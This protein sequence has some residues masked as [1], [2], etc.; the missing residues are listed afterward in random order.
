MT[1]T[2][3]PGGFPYRPHPHR[4]SG[5]NPDRQNIGDPGHCED[6]CSVGHLIA[7]PRYGCGDVG[8]TVDHGDDCPHCP[9]PVA[10]HTYRGQC[11]PPPAAP[12]PARKRDWEGRRVRT[13]VELRNGYG[14]I[15]PGTV[16]TVDRN[17]AGLHLV[18]D[19]CQCC[20][21]QPTI[22]KVPESAV[23]LLPATRDCPLCTEPM[24]HHTQPGVCPPPL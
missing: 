9:A 4:Y 18:G 17:Y 19:K 5:S 3:T 15:A 7:H 1:S 21:F 11:P 16:M 2:L 14:R 10:E 12:V 24:A 22:G 13:L 20:L 8:C 6:C 23:A